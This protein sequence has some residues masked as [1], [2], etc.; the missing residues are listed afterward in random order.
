LCFIY[1]SVHACLMSSSLSFRTSVDDLVGH[2]LSS[3]EL[4]GEWTNKR[5]LEYTISQKN[6]SLILEFGETS[7]KSTPGSR[8]QYAVCKGMSVG[9]NDVYGQHK[10]EMDKILDDYQCGGEMAADV[11]MLTPIERLIELAFPP[12]PTQKK[13]RTEEQKDD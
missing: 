5:D 10:Q 3:H 7:W 9:Y 12:L 2:V 4:V 6:S 11:L 1:V 13:T 8:S